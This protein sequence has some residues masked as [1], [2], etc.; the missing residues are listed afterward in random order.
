MYMCI[1]ENDNFRIIFNH[2]ILK[3]AVKSEIITNG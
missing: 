2:L 3:E 1:F